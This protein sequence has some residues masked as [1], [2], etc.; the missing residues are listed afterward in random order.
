VSKGREY[1]KSIFVH[2]F[3]RAIEKA[4]GAWDPDC[5]T[6]I[7]EAVDELIRDA[8]REAVHKS[9]DREEMVS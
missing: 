2:Y 4:G 1:A 5:A 7:E 9:I 8:V 3:R 6:E